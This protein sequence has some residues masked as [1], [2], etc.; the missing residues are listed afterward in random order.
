M[1]DV[2]QRRLR[3]RVLAVATA[4]AISS[5]YAS[6]AVAA[7][8]VD[9]SGLQSPEQKSFDRFIVKYRDGSSE[10]SDPAVLG[11]TLR[12]ASAAVPAKAGRSLEVRQLR[13]LAVGADVVRSDR[14]LARVE[15]ESLLRQ[16]AGNPHADYV[17]GDKPTK[18]FLT[19]NDTRFSSQLGPG[20]AAVSPRATAA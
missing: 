13:R 9:L 5:M 4:V 12:S 15:A 7:G 20:S 14:Q 10:R 19:P 6:A 1:T 8:R 11:N 17:E 16:I 2:S 18:P 3:L